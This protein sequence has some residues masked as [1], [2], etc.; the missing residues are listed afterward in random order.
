MNLPNEK[1]RLI[2]LAKGDANALKELFLAYH[3]QLFRRIYSLVKDQSLAD[4]LSQQVFIR[5]WDKRKTIYVES[6]F[7]AYLMKMGVNEALAHIRK[8]RAEII[9]LND[10]LDQKKSEETADAAIRAAEQ[11]FKINEAINLLPTRCKE[12]FLL[13]R[14]ENLSYQEIADTLSISKK[15]VE[16]QM[17]KALLIL[18]KN[19]LALMSTNFIDQI[20]F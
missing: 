17:G 7:A 20:F 11:A 18:R 5:L 4:D 10:R 8:Q 19:L 13:S 12:I 1:Q 14:R 6:N 9:P 15:T 3:P 2:D 16:V